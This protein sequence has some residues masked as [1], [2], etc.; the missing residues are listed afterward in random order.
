MADNKLYYG[1]NLVILREHVQD[2]SVDLVYLDPPF[3][4]NQN[5]NV[6][7]AEQDGQRSAAQIQAFEDTWQ[8][9]QAAARAFQEVVESDGGK[10][11]QAM[12][13]FRVSLGENNLLA[14]LSMMA[15]RLVEL[16]RVLKNTG[17]I[18][19]HCDPSASHYLKMLMDAVFGPECF[20]NEIVW[21]RTGSHGGSKR[22][23][24]IHDILFFYTK[25]NDFRWNKTYQEF[26]ETY[27]N[28][29][30][31]FENDKGR[32]RLVTLTGA[33]TRT[34]DSGKSWRNV[35]P[36][37]SGRHWAVPNKIVQKLIG[38]KTIDSL[39]VQEKLEV[40]DENDFIYWP[41]K[42]KVP[43]YKRYIDE[44]PG[45]P[46]QDIITDIKPISSQAKERLG[47]PTQKPVALL[48]RII[49]ASS[50]EGDVVLDPFCGCGTTIA[51]A[52]NLDRKW[53]G[54]DITHLA[55]S[56]MKTRIKDMFGGEVDFE[57]I[58]EPVSLSGAQELADYDKYQFEWWALSLV[59]ARPND[60]KKGADKGIDGR[61]YFHDEGGKAKTKQII[62]SVKG[63]GKVT[64][65]QLRDLRGVIDRESAEIGVLMSL[66]N[67]TSAMRKEA[68][69]AG[70]YK[71]PWD[72]K[73]YPRLQLLTIEELLDGKGIDYPPAEHVNVTHKK[74]QRAKK[75]TK[76]MKLGF[77]D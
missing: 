18:Y 76:Q 38:N 57:V 10:V 44:N 70:F 17:S 68:A 21:K 9:D 64:V 23:G 58:G 11:S 47:Y 7:F 27:L 71:S 45:V 13:G 25:T 65:S 60:K 59:A 32:Y 54:I 73:D 67:P 6:L 50:N 53:I 77:E 22:W 33:G 62:I 39:S 14:Y 3:N 55:V 69:S 63:G 66:A 2:E 42:G 29:F 36:T 46:I 24:P 15:P 51:A 28:D 5:Y 8:W 72:K 16:K 4:S 48:E 30:Y 37:T 1:D 19:L 35:D 49:E 40:L 12:Q 31:R 26:D 20:R 43:Q 75:K 34:G 61:L 74:A 52:Q 41:K 56:L